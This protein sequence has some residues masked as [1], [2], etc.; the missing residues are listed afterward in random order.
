[1]SDWNIKA[2]INHQVSLCH[3]WWADLELPLDI[4]YYG[5]CQG[6]CL[7]TAVAAYATY[8]SESHLLFLDFDNDSKQNFL[9][10][11]VCCFHICSL[12]LLLFHLKHKVLFTAKTCDITR[13]V[14]VCPHLQS[15]SVCCWCY[16]IE[17]VMIPLLAGNCNL[18]KGS[19]RLSDLW[20]VRQ[21]WQ[22]T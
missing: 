12:M 5:Q 13:S 14:K 10:L 7:K 11:H 9:S 21:P 8:L 2:F 15:A 17:S 4:G 6:T 3:G 20:L 18:R 1:M 16:T 22:H 19:C